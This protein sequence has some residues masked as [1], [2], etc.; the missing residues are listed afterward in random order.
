MTLEELAEQVHAVKNVLWW[1]DH[2]VA[3]EA[4]FLLEDALTALQA[5]AT[6]LE[7]VQADDNNSQL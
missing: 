7:R 6:E 3:G 2:F 1:K 4:V 5:C